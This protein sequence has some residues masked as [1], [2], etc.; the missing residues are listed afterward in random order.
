M[1]EPSS[2]AVAPFPTV[3]QLE[4]MGFVRC[5]SQPCSCWIN[6]TELKS[7]RC[8]RHQQEQRG[9]RREDRPL[10]ELRFAPRADRRRE[11]A[12]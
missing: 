7:G 10:A 8:Q 9:R 2:R 4:K 3:V 11:R 12:A 5:A 1:P 6:P